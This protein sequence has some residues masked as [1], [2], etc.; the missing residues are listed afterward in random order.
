MP[1]LGLPVEWRAPVEHAAAEY[2]FAAH[3]ARA[4]TENAAVVL[5]EVG[6]RG[7]VPEW[8]TTSAS[9]EPYS[10][11]LPLLLAGFLLVLRFARRAHAGP[12]RFPPDLLLL[13]VAAAIVLWFFAAP[14]PR[15]AMAMF[16]TAAA[17]LAAGVCQ[18]GAI[19]LGRSLGTV[20]AAITALG[21]SSVLVV[22]LIDPHPRI[23]KEPALSRVLWTALLLPGGDAWFYPT[24]AQEEGE[25]LVTATGLHLT[26]A[27][28]RCAALP[29]PCTPNPAP[30]VRL[31]TPGDIRS[32]FV[33]DGPWMMENWPNAR[34]LVFGE[35]WRRSHHA[36]QEG[37]SSPP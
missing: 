37:S 2:A 24:P 20:R 16:W 9:R 19:D 7:W 35:L 27:G 15:Y 33:V 21:L 31:R 13:P 4:S 14:E 23:R 3:S 5:G 36:E 17:I 11:I 8:W 26:V 30:N 10:L 25:A 6:I 1:V 34:R 12:G 18:A 29:P 32:G 28:S 22:P